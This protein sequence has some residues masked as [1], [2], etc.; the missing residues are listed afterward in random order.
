M[1]PVINIRAASVKDAGPLATLHLR[2][3]RAGFSH[4]FLAS[5]LTPSPAD[6]SADW[7]A[8]L[9]QDQQ[10]IRTT[11]VAEIGPDV[12]GVVCSAVGP[13]DPA[14]GRVARLYVDPDHWGRGVAAHLLRACLSHLRDQGCRVARAWVM[15]PNTRA[16]QVM[17][18]VGAKLTGARQPTCE[19]AASVPAGIE[20]VEYEILLQPEPAGGSGKP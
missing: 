6:M 7:L 4:I 2:S 3:A 16:R 20:D 12:A 5:Q 11:F 18:G 1:E 14:V 9:E 17:E 10:S 15:E 19:K 13:A 8:R